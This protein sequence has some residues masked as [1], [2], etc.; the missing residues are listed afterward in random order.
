VANW[1][2]SIKLNPEWDQCGGGEITRQELAASIARKLSAL[3]PLEHEQAEETRLEL[4]DSFEDM[5]RDADLSEAEFNG[6]M[7]DLYD[8]GDMA[9]DAS[10][11]GKKVCWIDCM[12]PVP[13]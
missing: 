7:D 1:Q 6:M 13:A 5:G 11:N 10:W 9:L 8:W 4:A 3:H 12:T 2:R